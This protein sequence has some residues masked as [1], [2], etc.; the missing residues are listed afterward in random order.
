MNT[1]LSNSAFIAYAITCLL[2]CANLLILWGYSGAARGKIKTSL[3]EE[4]VV[5]FG[6]SLVEI[7][8]PPV[9]RI[10]RAYSNA[11]A[12]IYPFLLVGLIYL[13][14][15]GTAGTAVA[16]FGIFTIARLLHSFAYLKGKQPWRT[17]FFVIGMLATVVLMLNTIWLLV[18]AA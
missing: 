9:A 3:N 11:N 10:L 12:S 6:G 16:L 5:M 1:W 2:L 7:D 18:R 15:G 4:D 17:I 8:P 13:L 14:A